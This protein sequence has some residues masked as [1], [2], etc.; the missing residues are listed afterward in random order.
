MKPT[1]W[2]LTQFGSADEFLVEMIGMGK[3]LEISLVGNFDIE[4]RGSRRDIDLPMHKDG[5]YSEELAKQ[6]GGFYI[7]KED[8]DYVGLYCIREGSEP[9]FTL[10]DAGEGEVAI[11]LRRGEALIL[12]NN[13]VSHGRRGPVGERLLIRAWIKA[14]DR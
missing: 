10:V 6:Q 9:C 7:A 13:K 14:L 5:Q 12:D 2:S 8:I 4:G 3:P 11:D 1:T